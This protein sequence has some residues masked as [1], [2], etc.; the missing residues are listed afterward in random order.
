VVELVRIRAGDLVPNR[1]NWRRH[2]AHQRAAVEGL[3]R[4]IGYADA[5]LARRDGDALILIDGHLRQSLDPDQV[6]PVLILDVSEAESETLLAT[7]DPLA[8]LAGSDT[9]AHA[10]LLQRI[11]STDDEV[12]A[13][14][15]RLA[16][17]AGIA[18][19]LPPDP[20][21]V[22]VSPPSRTQRGDL[23]VVGGHR[24]LCGDATEP[25]D[26]ERLMAGERADVV[27]TDPPYG[28]NYVGKTSRAMKVA[29]DAPEGLRE[30][31]RRAFS[32]FDPVLSAGA[33]IYLC[34][35]SGPG[36]LEVLRAF[37]DQ[38]WRLHQTLIWV[39]DTLVLGHT[40]YH[41]RH[42]PIAY[43]F[44]P[45]GGR[46]GRGGAGWYGGDAEDSILEVARPKASRQHPTMKPVELVIRCLRNSTRPGDRVLDP[47]G[48][49]GTT[50]AAAQ[51]LGRRGYAIELDPSY[52]DVAIARLEALTGVEAKLDEGAGASADG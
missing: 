44:A 49:S 38:G 7:L 19:V 52:C 30:L 9:E 34:H 4:E 50:L 10:A 29:G 18:P 43:G 25:S 5:L 36:A 32:A 39:K 15:E 24:L 31:L 1:A 8:A 16:R 3:L 23:W 45:G 51:M 42:E 33:A 37:T 27:W 40:D 13:L 47:F 46:R 20:D 26:M 28:V 11:E 17:E 12:R 21:D 22:P 35:Q 6:V 41:Y 48:G 14:L 2:P